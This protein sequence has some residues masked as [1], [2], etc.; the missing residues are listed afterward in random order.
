MD[1]MT[2]NTFDTFLGMTHVN[3]LL[4]HNGRGHLDS[5]NLWAT[6]YHALSGLA[7]CV[8]YVAHQH[9]ANPGGPEQQQHI[10]LVPAQ[11]SA[12]LHHGLHAEH[13]D[14]QPSG[15]GRADGMQGGAALLHGAAAVHPQRRCA[16]T[17]RRLSRGAGTQ[18]YRRFPVRARLGE[19]P[20]GLLLR[21]GNRGPA[22]HVRPGAARSGQSAARPV[23][24]A[25]EQCAIAQCAGAALHRQQLQR[26]G[27]DARNRQ[28]RYLPA[29]QPLSGAVE[30]RLGALLRAQIRAPPVGRGGG[31]WRGASDGQLSLRHR[32]L[33]SLLGSGVHGERLDRPQHGSAIATR[34]SFPTW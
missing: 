4:C 27:V 34:C 18:H 24:A 30:R 28:Q 20:V 10:L 25:A 13:D 7:A 21:P 23:D 6:Q 26:E 11:Q 3:C 22:G 1:Q 29:F 32:Y 33:G 9:G 2:A 5:I 15:A 14:R 19:L 17:R 16:E 12:Q 31:G 8:L